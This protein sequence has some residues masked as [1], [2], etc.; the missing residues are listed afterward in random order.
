MTPRERAL[1]A[2]RHEEPDYPP[3]NLSIEAGPARRL[4]EYFGG[5][6]WRQAIV[7]H[8]VVSG[9]DLGREELGGGRWRDKYGCVW[10][11]LNIFHT[12]EPVLKE[13]TLA[14]YEPPHNLFTP[15]DLARVKEFSES[16][17]DRLRGFSMGL[18]LFERAWALRGMENLLMDVIEH[19]RFVHELFDLLMELHFPILDQIGS[20]PGIDFVMFGDDFGMQQG[21]I[22]G[23]PHW[24]TFLKPRL[25]QLYERAHRWGKWV[26][27]HSCGDNS[28]I[29]E[30]LIEIGVDCFNPLQPE[31]QD[32]YALKRRYGRQ[33]AF[34][35]GIGTQQL[36]PHGTPEQIRA[37][38]R[39]VKQEMGRGGGLIL[40]TTK[41][42]LDDVP[43]ENAV[44]CIAA[45]LEGT[46]TSLPQ[47]GGPAWLARPESQ[48]R[49]GGEK[50]E[51]GAG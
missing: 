10:Q 8:V 30:D 21:I 28:P 50:K 27:I 17:P 46:D 38:V 7:N 35:G 29:M 20:L 2:L 6:H 14:G 26:F 22:M 40:E 36:L 42:I 19:P 34:W 41:P 48:P 49:A 13:P 16:Y 1:M 33:I 45:I 43:T 5:P 32:I 51:A 47:V 23:V 9:M 39:R 4:D 31:A 25:R 18:M 44:A 15:A 12:V 3:Y 11:D 24:R 37:E